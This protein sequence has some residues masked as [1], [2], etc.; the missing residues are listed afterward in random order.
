MLGLL[1]FCFFLHLAHHWVAA[2]YARHSYLDRLA[3]MWKQ[4]SQQHP[5]MEEYGAMVYIGN[6]VNCHTVTFEWYC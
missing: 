1:G 5:D 6:F 3:H 2:A 4:A